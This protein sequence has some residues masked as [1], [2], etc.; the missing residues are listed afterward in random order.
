MSTSPEA[1]TRDDGLRL[2][3]AGQVD[4]AVAALESALRS[5]PQD[6]QI[7]AFLGAHTI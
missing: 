1:L 2:L 4:E 5:A 6:P 7:H 3:K